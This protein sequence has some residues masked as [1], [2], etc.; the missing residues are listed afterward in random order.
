[1]SN[2]A[3]PTLPADG[4]LRVWAPDA[5]TVELQPGGPITVEKPVALTR[6][7][8]LAAAGRDRKSVV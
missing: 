6:D 7:E 5:G 4:R 1:M 3:L 2:P 8:D